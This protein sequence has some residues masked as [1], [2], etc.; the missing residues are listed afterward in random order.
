MERKATEAKQTNF[1]YIDDYLSYIKQHVN[2][3]AIAHKISKEEFN[4]KMWDTFEEGLG[5]YTSRKLYESCQEYTL[6]AYYKRIKAIEEILERRFLST[7]SEVQ[8]KTVKSTQSNSKIKGNSK[9]CKHHQHNGH[10]T[11]DCYMERDKV[12][13]NKKDETRVY[14]FNNFILEKKNSVTE[15]QIQVVINNQNYINKIYER[16][17]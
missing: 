1:C 11:R 2:Y 8:Y 14:D 3:Y 15:L 7:A 10:D 17:I 5:K 12:K 16:G 4:R 6:Q 9:W 13:T